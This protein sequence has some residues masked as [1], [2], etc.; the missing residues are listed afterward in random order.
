MEGAS[1]WSLE[2]FSKVLKA[3]RK[4]K[5]LSQAELSKI[6]GVDQGSISRYERADR[7]PSSQVM[8]LLL[9]SLGLRLSVEAV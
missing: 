1:I 9:S 2:D 6:S 4:A 5:G 7:W 8:I 3:R